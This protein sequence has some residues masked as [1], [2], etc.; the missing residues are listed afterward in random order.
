MKRTAVLF[1]ANVST[2][3]AQTS[4]ILLVKKQTPLPIS[5]LNPPPRNGSQVLVLNYEHHRQLLVGSDLARHL[6]IP[7]LLVRNNVQRHHVSA[8]APFRSRYGIGE[9]ASEWISGWLSG[10]M[11]RWKNGRM[12]EWLDG[13][14]AAEHNGLVAEQCLRFP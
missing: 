3:K 13:W 14:L 8:S 4:H 9:G 7:T 11:G 2:G 6:F 1:G 5:I 12:G 10:W